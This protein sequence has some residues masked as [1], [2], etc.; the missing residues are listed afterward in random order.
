MISY[1]E[2]VDVDYPI[3]R[4]A[5]GDTLSLGDV[6]LLV[7]ATPG[8]TPESISIVVYEH[9]DDHMPYGVLTGDTLFIGDVGRPDLL[10]SAGIS[11]D[12][13][14]SRPL[15]LAARTAA[16]AARH[17]RVFPAHGAGSACGKHLS[18]ETQSTIGEQ[19][20]HNYAL[21]P[22]GED[23][24]VGARDRGSALAAR[25]LL[26]RRAAQP[27]SPFAARRGRRRPRR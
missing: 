2:A 21:Q 4:L 23:E 3:E 7:L 14:G 11:A 16:P 10:S 1:G 15:P 5:D 27:R 25:L 12:E 17:T 20:A 9:G 13:L 26:V 8:H 19:R 22:M 18:T 6:K 24:F